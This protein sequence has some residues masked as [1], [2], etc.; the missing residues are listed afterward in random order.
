MRI[1]FVFTGG[2]IGSVQ[3]GAYVGT[4]QSTA[5]LLVEQYRARYGV[6][7][8]YD[9]VSPYLALSEQ[10]DGDT[11]RT[12]CACV[13]AHMDKGYDGIVVTHGTDTLQYAA[14]ALSYACADAGLTNV[15]V[16][17]CTGM[18]AHY[19][20]DNGI[21]VIVKGIRGSADAE[22]E[23]MVDEVNKMVN[24]QAETMLLISNPALGML[25]S[26]TVR[27]LLRYGED[28]SKLVPASVL[29]RVKK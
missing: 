23:R 9:A 28:V 14:A 25:S 7:F 19:V 1:L 27:E 22:Y 21:D 18:V 4:D 20:R 6:P 12:L 13:R 3:K 17:I 29:K 5:S 26:S 2:T 11:L 24:P 16:E 8:A 10:S 15:K